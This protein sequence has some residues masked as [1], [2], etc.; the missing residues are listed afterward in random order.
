MQVNPLTINE[1][2]GQLYGGIPTYYLVVY[3]GNKDVCTDIGA[4]DG[5]LG[6]AYVIGHYNSMDVAKRHQEIASAKTGAIVAVIKSGHHLPLYVNPP[7][8]ITTTYRYNPEESMKNIRK[9]I[10]KQR[11]RTS[12]VKEKKLVDSTEQIEKMIA[13]AEEK[14]ESLEKKQNLEAVDKQV[15][16]LYYKDQLEKLR[17]QVTNIDIT[18]ETME[19]EDR[20]SMSFLI[21]QLYKYAS[22]EESIESLRKIK[23]ESLANTKDFF[24]RFPDAQEKWREEAKKRFTERGEENLYNLINKYWEKE[25]L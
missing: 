5:F 16:T 6:I 19:R 14:L 7:A 24:A 18:N 10:L 15:L 13:D 11:I 20:E 9:E 21:N 2:V 23:D 8:N 22:A 12:Q 25:N 3:I 4:K 1:K 17:E